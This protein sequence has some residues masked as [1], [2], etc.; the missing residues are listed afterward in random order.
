VLVTDVEGRDGVTPFAAW[1]A[2]Y[3]LWPYW[4]LI[5]VVLSLAMWGTLRKRQSA[6][7]R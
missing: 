3:G 5:G 2:R 1:V 7:I 6:A 4:V